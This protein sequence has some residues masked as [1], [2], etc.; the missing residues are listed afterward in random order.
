MTI[1]S[2][3]SPLANERYVNLETFRKD[4]TTVKTPVWVAPLDGKLVVFCDA[5]SYKVKRVR[6]N[7]KL[8]A[9]ACSARGSILGD[10][11]DGTGR[12]VEDG[13]HIDRIETALAAKYGFPMKA[14]TLLKKVFG[15]GT[16]GRA[17]LEISI[18]SKSS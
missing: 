15:G 3:L 7:P 6:N 12:V 8:R 10:W 5:K 11:L 1:E 13:A 17:Y 9:A 18:E 14:I 16:K 2:A 4:G